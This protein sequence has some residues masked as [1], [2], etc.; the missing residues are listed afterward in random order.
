MSSQLDGSDRKTLRGAGV[1]HPSS[2]TVFEDNL[3]YTDLSDQAIVRVGR[4]KGDNRFVFV[5]GLHKGTPQ[6]VKAVHS[7]RQPDFGV[8][9]TPA[10]ATATDVPAT[11][12]PATEG[13]LG[14]GKS[15]MTPVIIGVSVG[16]VVLILAVILV[17]FIVRRGSSG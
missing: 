2:V 13:K 17:V 10:P 9:L 12:V 14:K 5:D 7:L 3:F 6:D 1:Q 15:S 8:V 4:V 16:V 11:D